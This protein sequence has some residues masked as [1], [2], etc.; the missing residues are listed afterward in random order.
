MD[1]GDEIY[2]K[3][4]FTKS[5]TPKKYEIEYRRRMVRISQINFCLSRS[6][7]YLSKFLSFFCWSKSFFRSVQLAL[8]KSSIP[9]C[10]KNWLNSTIF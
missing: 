9:L 5:N 2:R 6:Q 4:T 10:C 7:T 8:C 1:K 3:K